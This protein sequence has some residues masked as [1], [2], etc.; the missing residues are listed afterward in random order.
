L[1]EKQKLSVITN[2]SIL[3][4]EIIDWLMMLDFAVAISHDG[5]GQSVRG[6][7]PV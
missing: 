7:D 5:P 3:S 6:P 4:D 1:E 2:G